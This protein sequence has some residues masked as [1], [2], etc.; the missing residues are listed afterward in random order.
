MKF[1][2]PDH[3]P[4]VGCWLLI[5]LNADEVIKAMRTTYIETRQH[6]MTYVSESGDK[7]VGRFEW[8]YP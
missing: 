3:L 6:E 1:N 7:H 8:T 4:P 2:S 5:K